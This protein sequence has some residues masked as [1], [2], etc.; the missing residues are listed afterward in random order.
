MCSSAEE[1]FTKYIRGFGKGEG[2]IR[3]SEIVEKTFGKA[4]LK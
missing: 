4:G 3:S 1:F 2:N